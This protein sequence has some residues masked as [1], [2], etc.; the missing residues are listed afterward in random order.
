MSISPQCNLHQQLLPGYHS[1]SWIVREGPMHS[2]LCGHPQRK[3]CGL[4]QEANRH[5]NIVKV[6]R[7]QVNRT[8]RQAQA[9]ES[10]I[11]S[12]SICK[13]TST[14]VS[15]ACTKHPGCF[16]SC[17]Q[18]LCNM[19]GSY[20]TDRVVYNHRISILCS[21]GCPGFKMRLHPYLLWGY[22][23]RWSCAIKH[24]E[25][26]LQP[27]FESGALCIAMGCKL[28]MQTCHVAAPSQKTR[29]L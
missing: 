1:I 11:T 8:K 5:L 29:S 18:C 14:C 4:L 13:H 7:K 21:A 27:E 6:L 3:A 26:G 16:G 22:W 28:C 12:I 17:Q 19:T 10:D 25:T 23:Y 9:L 2:N 15:H 24:A 20:S